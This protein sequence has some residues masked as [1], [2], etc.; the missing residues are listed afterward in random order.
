MKNPQILQGASDVMSSGSTAI[1][2]CCCYLTQLFFIGKRTLLS[3]LTTTKK[4]ILHNQISP[5]NI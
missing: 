3:D 4:S 2:Y 1:K 5:A